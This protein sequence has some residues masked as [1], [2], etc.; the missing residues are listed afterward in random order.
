[1]LDYVKRKTDT[2][3]LVAR[4]GQLYSLVVIIQ[5]FQTQNAV[6]DQTE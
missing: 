3:K 6:I 1:M 2:C 4:D 5:N